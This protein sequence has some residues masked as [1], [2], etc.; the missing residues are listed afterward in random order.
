[1]HMMESLFAPA[2]SIWAPVPSPGIGWYQT[3]VG[4]GGRSTA[5]SG[6]TFAPVPLGMPE[7]SAPA[8][9][10]AVAMR[11]GQPQGPATDQDVEEFI[12]DTFELLA[13][14]ADVDVR[15][16]AGRVT[17]TGTVSHKRLKH[18]LGEIAWAIPAVTD[19]HNN[20]TIATRRRGRSTGVA[21][22]TDAQSSAPA[23]KQ[24]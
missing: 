19:V 13:G 17:L 12:Y 1:M 3:P 11:R 23:R 8:L 4:V 20:L 6:P 18:D 10:A 16:E 2:P 21:K 14:A 24:A 22:E 7:I 15:S 5:P 9:V